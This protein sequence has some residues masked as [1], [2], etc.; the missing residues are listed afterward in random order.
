MNE[1]K[2]SLFPQVY[3]NPPD[4]DGYTDLDPPPPPSPPLPTDGEEGGAQEAPP[5]LRGHWDKR[6][7]S[8]QK[9]IMTKA[10]KEEKVKRICF[11]NHSFPPSLS[12][13]FSFSLLSLS[14]FLPHSFSLSP[15]TLSLFKGCF[16]CC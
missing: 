9:L 4:W 12:H 14:L 10:F 15:H 8:F 11:Q 1:L 6:L 3:A 2:F 7:T 13:S 5:T 16:C